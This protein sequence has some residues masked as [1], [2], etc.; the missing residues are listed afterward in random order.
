MLLRNTG[1]IIQRKRIVASTGPAYPTSGLVARW[2]FDNTLTDTVSGKVL[3]GTPDYRTGKI[4]NGIYDSKLNKTAD[5]DLSNVWVNR[6]AHSISFWFKWTVSNTTIY[7]LVGTGDNTSGND[8]EI[9]IRWNLGGNGYIAFGRNNQTSGAIEYA[10]SNGSVADSNWHHFIGLY[11]GEDIKVYID[12]DLKN[13]KSFSTLGMTSKNF[14]IGQNYAGFDS[15]G[16]TID[17][18][19]LYNKVLDITEIAQLYNSGNGI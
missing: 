19:Y 9:C 7:H 10:H 12:N 16:G 18:F 4:N 2:T 11:T 8:R 5:T 6:S 17:Q 14:Y 1:G 13:T 15:F 3:S